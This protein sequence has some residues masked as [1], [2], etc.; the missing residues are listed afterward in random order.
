MFTGTLFLVCDNG[1]VVATLTLPVGR[2]FSADD[3]TAYSIS[4]SPLPMGT[5]Q[6]MRFNSSQEAIR[7]FK[8]L[9]FTLQVTTIE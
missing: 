9:E 4:G 1:G 8:E 7:H 3:L 2:P 6:V 5:N